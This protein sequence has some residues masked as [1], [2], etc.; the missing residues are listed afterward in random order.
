MK[1]T[2]NVDC[3]PEEARAFLGLPDLGPV[4]DKYIQSLLTAMDG[5]ASLEQ[6]D[7]MMRAFSPMGDAGLKLFGQMMDIGLSAGKAATKS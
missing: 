1:V 7:K 2:V 6:M 5:A 3:S 4:H